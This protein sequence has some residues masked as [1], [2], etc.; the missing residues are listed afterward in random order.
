MRRI[1]ADA[2]RPPSA[3]Q[4]RG[5]DC[6][7]AL[8]EMP[9]RSRT[10]I[11]QTRLPLLL[12]ELRGL[13]FNRQPAVSPPLRAPHRT[14]PRHG[15]RQLLISNVPAL[16]PFASSASICLLLRTNQP[17]RAAFGP[18]PD[19]GPPETSTTNTAPAHE[20]NCTQ[21]TKPMRD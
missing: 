5:A 15:F 10:S 19:L 11:S 14:R 16:R 3:D 17:V 6:Q 7:S 2:N 20:E 1:N 18:Q 9:P 13:L 12:C 4:R 21:A 8:P